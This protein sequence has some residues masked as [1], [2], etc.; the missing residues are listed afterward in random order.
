MDETDD[1]PGSIARMKLV[2]FTLATISGLLGACTTTA[3]VASAPQGAP[4]YR[5]CRPE[6]AAKLV[7]QAAPD[8][9][10][11]QARTGAELIRRIAPGDAV[12]HDFREN[13]ITLAID[14]AGKVVQAS[15]G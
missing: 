6:G 9:A 13:R 3:Q 2:I 7:G 8:N 12:T 1:T 5:T 4:V 10:H 14:P 15:C 11:I